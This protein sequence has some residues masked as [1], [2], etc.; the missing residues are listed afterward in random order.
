MTDS[1]FLDGI[2]GAVG[3]FHIENGL[4]LLHD[5]LVQQ[6]GLVHLGFVLL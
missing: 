3:L 4:V 6:S 5:L 1:H 2:G